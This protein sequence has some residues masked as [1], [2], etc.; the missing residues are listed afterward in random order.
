[1]KKYLLSIFI[2]SFLQLSFGKEIFIQK[3]VVG[4]KEDFMIVQYYKIKGTNKKIGRKIA[5]IAKSLN[6][7]INSSTDTLKN[8]LKYKYLKQN[9]PI[10]YKRMQGIADE[11]NIKIDDYSKD[12]S[13]IPYI[14][15]KTN[16]SVIFYPGHHTENKHDILSRNYDFTLGNINLQKCEKNELPICSRPI[17]FEIYP[18]T[19]YASLYITA[20]DLIGGAVDGINSQGLSIAVL[21]EG[22]AYEGYTLEPSNEV[23]LYE[24]LIMRYLLDNCKNVEEA[25]IA[26]LW[27]KQ[28]YLYL[29]LHYIIAD[30]HG[31]SFVFEFSRQRNR[32]III[33]GKG[34]QCI[35]THLLSNQHPSNKESLE[36]LNKLKSITHTKEIF[37]LDEIKEINN[38]VSPR[39]TYHPF[40]VPSRTL[41]HAMYDLDSKTLNVKFYLGETKDPKN[42]N[43][44]ITRYSDYF[45]FSFDE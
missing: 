18:D 22:I 19:G 41:W 45:E 42:N 36:N 5:Q 35:T 16:C 26:L 10:H 28:Y 34:I 40:Y 43:K 2:S 11:Y 9:Y 6:I 14:P 31:K 29:P 24:L 12:I 27:L 21:S 38:K 1:M 17:I 30:N 33:D 15:T 8:K 13:I 7:K 32:S 4:C 44:I 25:K 3:T 23:G 37:T 20:F 39:M